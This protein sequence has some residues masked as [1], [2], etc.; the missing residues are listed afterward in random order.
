MK[1]MPDLEFSSFAFRHWDSAG[2]EVGVLI[3]K[4]TFCIDDGKPL[5]RYTTPQLPFLY[6]DSYHGEQNLSAIKQES[7][8]APFKP[9]TDVTLNAVARSPEAKLLNGWSVQIEVKGAL[10]YGFDVTGER[11]WEVEGTGEASK[12]VLSDIKPITELPLRYEYAYGGMVPDSEESLIEH[13]Y[14]PIGRGLLT[15]YLL[16]Q[17]Q[18]VPAPQIGLAADFSTLEAGRDITVCGCGPI[19]KSWLPRLAFAG[20]LDEAWQRERHPCMPDNFEIAYWN[21]AP[22]PLQTKRGYLR[23]DERIQLTGLRHEPKPYCFDLPGIEVGCKVTRQG[24]LATEY[25]ILNLDG[26]HC[27]VAAEDPKLHWVSLTWRIQLER[28]D[29]I[30]SLMLFS[31]AI[32]GRVKDFSHERL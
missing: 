27:D 12:W 13:P 4:A 7:D 9:F 16:N 8:L 25:P 14:N 26:V 6:S 22:L 18:A 29:E 30:A 10:S 24:G 2:N 17:G 5:S 20:T 21:H 32:D 15:D 3:A 28:P 19:T 11:S 1:L 31:R 23:G